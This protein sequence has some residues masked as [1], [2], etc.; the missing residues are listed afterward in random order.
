MA[1]NKCG[2][3]ILTATVCA[4]WPSKP[5]CSEPIRKIVIDGDFRDWV[6]VPSHTDPSHNEH[7]TSH[8]GRFDRPGHVEHADVDLLEY[9]FTHD[10]DHLYAYFKTR[11]VIGRTQAAGPGKEAGRYYAILAIDLDEDENTGYWLHEGGFYPTS[12]GY[13]MNAEIEW[14]NGRMNAGYYINHACRDDKELQQ[15][16]LDQSSGKYRKGND[17]PY[18]P[19]FVRLGPGTYE[20]Y[21]QWVYH[22]DR[23]ITFVRDKG[24]RQVGII[25]GALSANGHE[26][27]MAI[28]FKGFLVDRAGSPVMKLG[29]KLNISFSLEASGELAADGKWASNTAEPIRGY[30]LEPPRGQ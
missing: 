19:G 14:Y 10:A 18:P 5:T 6:D 3:V 26:L 8:K 2:L 11:G 4:L 24:P 30:Y 21:S 20:F 13:D 9:K 27:E 25:K 28:P 1:V 29:R 12:R 22:A 23:R 7:D 15:A 17:G 16:L